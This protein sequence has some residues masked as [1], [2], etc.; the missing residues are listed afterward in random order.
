MRLTSGAADVARW[1]AWQQ[2]HGMN[3]V[4]AYPASVPIDAYGA[5]GLHPFHRKD[6]LWDVDHWNEEYF[7]HLGEVARILE[8]HGIM[9]HLQLWQIVWF[10]SGSTRWEINYLNPKNNV[11][12][13][14]RAFTRG[15]EYIDAPPGSPARAHQEAWVRR[16]LDSLSPRNNVWID[17]INELGNEMGTLEWAREVTQWI[18]AWE[19]ERGRAFLVGVDSEQHYRPEVFDPAREEFDLIILNELRSPGHAHTVI[20]TFN[21]PAV[22]VRSSDESNQWEHYMFAN[23]EQ[24][25][26]EHQTRYR[27]LCYRSL[28]AGVQS[29]GAY[30]KSEV[31]QADYAAME[32]WPTYARA[33]RTFWERLRPHWPELVVD[34]AMIEAGAVTPH[35]YALRAPGL[36]ALY[37]ECGPRTW[38]NPYPASELRIKQVFPESRVSL[39]NPRTGAF[40]QAEVQASEGVLTIPLPEFTDDLALLITPGEA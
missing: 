12:E 20:N 6:G 19:R 9:L 25:G 23:A 32:H 31:S 21:L 15:R 33:L 22:T 26:P 13:W 29:V 7:E 2:A 16:I 34:D 5:P 1:A 27:T 40:S 24:T 30:W 14:T 37:L 4:R 36:C 39:F 8:D 28:F 10:K 3:L 18:R 35:A 11:N 17:V 38:N